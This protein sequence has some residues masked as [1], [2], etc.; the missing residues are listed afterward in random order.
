MIELLLLDVLYFVTV[1]KLIT[2]NMLT[3]SIIKGVK[4]GFP[5]GITVSLSDFESCLE[6]RNSYYRSTQPDTKSCK[7]WGVGCGMRGK[8]V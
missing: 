7:M 3:S 2:H 1:M 6:L 4:K 8:S 5:L